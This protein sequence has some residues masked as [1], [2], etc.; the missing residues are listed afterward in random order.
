MLN[1]GDSFLLSLF[2][3]LIP[4]L[5]ILIGVFV[6]S[7]VIITRY[8][9]VIKRLYQ[10]NFNSLETERKRISN[11]LHDQLGY[12]MLIINKSIENLKSNPLLADNEELHACRTVKEVKRSLVSYKKKLKTLGTE[13]HDKKEQLAEKS[14]YINKCSGKKSAVELY[15]NEITATEKNIRELKPAIEDQKVL[16]TLIKALLYL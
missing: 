11:D 14:A 5:T 9:R 12:K 10:M 4:A 7:K 2:F 13:L 8:S 16:E 6:Y 1:S 3:I 15:T